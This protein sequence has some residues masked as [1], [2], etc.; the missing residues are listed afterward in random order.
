MSPVRTVPMILL[1]VCA[2]VLAVPASAAQG[3]VA[4]GTAESFAVLAGSGITNTGSTTIS[5][6][7]GTFPTP[8]ETGFGS[9]TLH[10]NNRHG[11]T[12]T[13]QAKTSLVTAY[14]DAAGRKPRTSVPVELG[15]KTLVAGVYASPTLGL[16]GT[17]TLDGKG[18]AGAQFVFQAASTLITA[19]NARV[20][21]INGADACHVVWKVG[22]SATFNTGTQFVGDVLAL[23]SITANTKATFRGRLLARNGS[24]TLDTNTIT[25]STCARAAP[26]VTAAPASTLR[27]HPQAGPSASPSIPFTGAPTVPLLAIGLTM[28]GLGVGASI[29]GTRSSRKLVRSSGVERRGRHSR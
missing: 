12:T 26:A 11:D 18:N 25:R 13:Q 8:S 3:R 24:V 16:T 22:S 1:G 6:D 7:V 29:L 5:G 4:L 19:P 14:N 15:G 20:R 28:V 2:L 27:N 17:L 9:V 10:G 21:L 23:T